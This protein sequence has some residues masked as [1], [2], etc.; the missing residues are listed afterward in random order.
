M[1][2]HLNLEQ[3]A[4]LVDEEA[5]ADEARHLR[6]CAR[7]AAELEQMNAQSRELA[8]LP[9]PAVPTHL[10]PVLESRLTAEGLVRPPVA[11]WMSRRHA[12][13]RV[14][15]A[16]LLFAA[17]AATSRALDGTTTPAEPTS[18]QQIAA[19]ATPGEAATLVRQTESAYLD[20]LTRYAELSETGQTIDPVNRLAALEGIV[21]TTRAALQ[22][23]PADPVINGYHLAA[24]SQREALLRQIDQELGEGAEDEWF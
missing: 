6:D 14:A 19:V 7:C 13:L 24:L 9:N 21:Y 18:R 22:E 17:G 15:A 12:W 5:S 23:S 16:V 1:Q 10:W 4:R 2:Q 8:A 20:A 3:V 11:P